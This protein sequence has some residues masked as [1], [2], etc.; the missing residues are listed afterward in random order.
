MAFSEL[1]VHGM[2]GTPP[3]ELLYSDPVSY[4]SADPFARIYE[5]NRDGKEVKAFHWG[6][7]T[8]GSRSSA[9]WLL[10]IPFMLANLAGWMAAS[11]QLVQAFIRLTGILITALLVAQGSVVLISHVNEIFDGE[12]YH[13]WAVAGGAFV[14]GSLFVVIV[15]RLSATSLVEKMSTPAKFRALFGIGVGTLIPTDL[16]EREK[17][18]QSQ[19]PA[20]GATLVDP[21]MW[22][23]QWVLHRLRRQHLAAGILVIPIALDL[24]LGASGFLLLELL[25]VAVI[26][27]D[28]AL[29]PRTGRFADAI[30]ATSSLQVY[31]AFGLFLLALVRVG[32]GDP[33]SG[34]WPHVHELVLYVAILAGA[35]SAVAVLA[36]WETGLHMFLPLSAMAIGALVGG[37]L[38]VAAGLL[39]EL[40]SY[41]WL[42]DLNPF[43]V[44]QEF[45]IAQSRIMVNGGAWTVET[46][47]CFLM[48]MVALAAYAGWARRKDLPKASD[49][50]RWTVMRKVTRQA[51]RVFGGTG[52]MA[53]VLAIPAAL[54]ACAGGQFGCDPTE[55]QP[56]RAGQILPYVAGVIA[57]FMFA[58][59]TRAIFPVS[60]PIAVLVAI[61]G[62]A[63]IVV[64][65]VEWF[66][67]FV[68]T[69]P[70]ID[71]PVRPARFLDLSVVVIIFGL[72]FFILRSIL[73]GFGDPEK[74]RKVGML[75]DTGSFWPR[76]FH[77]LAPPSYSPH[78][79]KTLN[80][81][82]MRE[83]TEI[84]TAHSQGSVIACVALSQPGA[85]LPGALV[86]YGSPL[87]ILYDKLFP[88]AG[89]RGLTSHVDGLW[90]PVS[91]W[92][93][94]WRNSDPLGGAPVPCI[95]RNKMVKKGAGHSHYELTDEFLE[96]RPAAMTGHPRVPR[97]GC[98]EP[99]S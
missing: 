38:G 63:A 56:E 53:S 26:L 47:L 42:G 22:V 97:T 62:V 31:L 93:N 1:R 18:L 15:W 30:R 96:A 90:G 82:L 5:A 91:H 13:S 75:W 4:D 7:L 32:F 35:T 17:S 37:A 46:M 23:R 88:F 54:F 10:L 50:C 79:V 2:S 72:T 98:P 20:P 77:P 94:L 57:V 21:E 92:V 74:R 83:E 45:D 12:P 80:A 28:V 73:G 86:T 61:G 48:A 64:V 34:E 95:S 78:A 40:A 29:T 76:W 44:G 19:D 51:P 8:S 60:R 36:Q 52:A 14:L 25:V 81:S 27:L 89:V 67:Q 87:G 16:D 65:F 71:L 3:R 69:V 39:A 33:P 85:T 43:Q 55:L 9:F 58:A 59:L 11:K 84:L 99:S 68:W 6:S 66:E 41:R 70:A 24:G 49:A